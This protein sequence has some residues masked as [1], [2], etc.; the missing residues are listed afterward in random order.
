MAMEDEKVKKVRRDLEIKAAIRDFPKVPKLY[1]EWMWD[2]VDSM[3]KEEQDEI[4]QKGLWEVP[5]K[6]T[7]MKETVENK[8]NDICYSNGSHCKCV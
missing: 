3:S 2:V 8:N 7:P 6:F 1:V 4:I 5:G